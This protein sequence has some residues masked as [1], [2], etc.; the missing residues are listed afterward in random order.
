MNE[1]DNVSVNRFED[2]TA[3]KT[4]TRALRQEKNRASG[5]ACASKPRGGWYAK[6]ERPRFAEITLSRRVGRVFNI[7]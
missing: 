4:K 6:D 2:F 3:L 1:R 5:S 7:L